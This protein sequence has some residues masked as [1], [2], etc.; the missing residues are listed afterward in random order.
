[1][2]VEKFIVTKESVNFTIIS[3]QILQHLNNVE[4]LGLYCFLTSL[5]SVWEFNKKHLKE[6]FNIGTNKI[7][8]L[9]KILQKHQLLNIIPVR[10]AQGQFAHFSIHVRN[11]KDF[12]IPSE[13]NKNNELDTNAHHSMETMPMETMPMENRTYKENNIKIKQKKIKHTYASNDAREKFEQFWDSYPRKKDK[14]RTEQ[15]WIKQKCNKNAEMIINDIQ[16]RLKND[17]QWKDH[18][19]IPYASTYLNGKRW[20]DEIT[21]NTHAQ[22]KSNNQLSR[23]QESVS[24]GWDVVKNW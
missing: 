16:N 2:S 22:S 12:I 6:K 3:N 11:G 9:F 8:K 1:M 18:Q 24:R 21:E 13:D 14:A 5:P 7:D 23:H 20:E 15:V 4:A 10:N 17:H 19:F